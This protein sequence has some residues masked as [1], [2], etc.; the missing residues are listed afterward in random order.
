MSDT[1]RPHH[2]GNLRDALIDAGLALLREGG[3]GAL[4]LRRAAARAGVSHA[5]PAHHFDGL[6]GLLTAIATRA[7]SD[8]TAAMQTAQARA[9][10]TAFGGVLGICRGYMDYAEQNSGLFHLIFVSPEVDRS[11]PALRAAADA[12][13]GTLRRAC[14]PF[15]ADGQPDGVTE[16]AVWS[17]VHGFTLLRLNS[18]E[19]LAGRPDFLLLL[20]R[21]LPKIAQPLLPFPES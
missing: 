17:L 20:Q 10:P 11:D 9:E 5:A 3:T 12:A 13:Y 6:R 21:V 1:A 19:T 16:A 8:F 7:F 4:T 15:S 14:L 18:R 2:H